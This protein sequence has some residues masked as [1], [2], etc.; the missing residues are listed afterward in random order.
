VTVLGASHPTSAAF[1]HCTK[2]AG[3]NFAPTFGTLDEG[4]L[5]SSASRSAAAITGPVGTGFVNVIAAGVAHQHRTLYRI[6]PLE[7]DL[8]PDM[9]PDSFR[10]QASISNGDKDGRRTLMST[11]PQV[12]IPKMCYDM[13]WMS[14]KNRKISNSS[15]SGRNCRPQPTSRPLRAIIITI[16]T[17]SCS[18]LGRDV[19]TLVLHPGRSKANT[20][21][22][23]RSL[24]NN[25][26]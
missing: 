3:A 1:Q 20:R 12:L 25:L 24:T 26:E 7:S 19:W 23:P 15:S 21:S 16:R 5:P 22:P 11:F 8:P 9:S 6:P 18:T 4:H 10:S 2:C 14:T 13:L 17:A